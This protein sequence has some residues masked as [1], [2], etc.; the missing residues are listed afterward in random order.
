M[1][2]NQQNAALPQMRIRIKQRS[3]L[4]VQTHG[5]SNTQFVCLGTLSRIAGL[6]GN[7]TDVATTL[8]ANVSTFTPRGTPAVLDGPVVSTGWVSTIAD[9]QDTMVKV[10]TTASIVVNTARVELE[11][12]RIGFN[13]NRDRSGGDGLHERR[14]F[15]HRGHVLKPIDRGRNRTTGGG[16]ACSLYA[17]VRVGILGTDTTVADDVLESLIHHTT[18]ATLVAFGSTAIHQ[19]LFGER[20]EIASGNGMATFSGS[21]GRESPASTTCSLIRDPCDVTSPDPVH[22]IG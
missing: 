9:N 12:L 3:R 5:P 16:L 19:L 1:G 13:G 8:N 14:V 15:L 20:N 17:L 22:R 7:T 18:A 10:G 4:I 11:G 6:H 2:T 21:S